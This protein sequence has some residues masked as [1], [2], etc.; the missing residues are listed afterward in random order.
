MLFVARHTMDTTK[1]SWSGNMQQLWISANGL[2]ILHNHL[3]RAVIHLHVYE[4]DKTDTMHK[5]PWLFPIWISMKWIFIVVLLMEQD[6]PSTQIY[7]LHYHQWTPEKNYHSD[8]IFPTGYTGR[9]YFSN[10]WCSRWLNF[11]QMTY[12]MLHSR[13]WFTSSS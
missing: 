13:Y 1:K 2:C 3:S 11:R 4:I 10:F 6:T 5:A 9:C 8:E 7:G 12:P